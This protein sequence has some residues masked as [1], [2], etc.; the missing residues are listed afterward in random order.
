MDRP[1]VSPVHCRAIGHSS[2]CPRSAAS[3]AIP[4]AISFALFAQPVLVQASLPQ[5]P[6][7][8]PSCRSLA[9]FAVSPAV[10][11]AL[12]PSNVFVFAGT[13][14]LLALPTSAH[15]DATRSNFNRLG[16]GRHRN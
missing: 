13:S 2:E 1:C 10:A 6:A 15:T 3:L 16:K 4:A 5:L 14:Q 9:H 12:L 7:N 8:I 11:F